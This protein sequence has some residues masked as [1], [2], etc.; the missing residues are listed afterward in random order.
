M[1]AINIHTTE[2]RPAAW[3]LAI[4]LAFVIGSLVIPSSASAFRMDSDSNPDAGYSSVNALVGGSGDAS[5][6]SGAADPSSGYSSLNAI[7]G[8]TK[9]E[10]TLVW[11]PSSTAD[12]GF[13]W[14]SAAIGAGA[15]LGMLSLAGAV[16]LTTRRRPSVST[17]AMH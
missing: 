3:R 4:A 2:T 14:A 8:P 5:Q 17:A 12:D 6:V 13:D 11:Y 1:G 16:V 7:T 15:I 9:D 10:P